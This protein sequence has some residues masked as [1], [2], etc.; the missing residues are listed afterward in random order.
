MNGFG[1]ANV[2]NDELRE[3]L[4]IEPADAGVVGL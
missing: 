3:A 4:S 2:E 1:L